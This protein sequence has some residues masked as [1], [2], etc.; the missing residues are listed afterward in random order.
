MTAQCL[1]Y[2]V[3]AFFCAARFDR[4]FGFRF[5]ISAKF[6]VYLEVDRAEYHEQQR[7]KACAA[8][9]RD[10]HGKQ[11]DVDYRVYV[12][13]KQPCGVRCRN[14]YEQ[15]ADKREFHTAAPLYV[16]NVEYRRYYQPR[17][18]RRHKYGHIESRIEAEADNIRDR[19][20][21]KV[22]DERLLFEVERVQH[23]RCYVLERQ[24]YQ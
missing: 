10:K 23:R 6:E 17:A 16:Y 7:H 3:F 8:R 5:F 1:R 20:A 13:R 14:A 19:R 4:L 9:R 22:I 18:E 11:F 15:R 2:G 21:Y 24:R 12:F